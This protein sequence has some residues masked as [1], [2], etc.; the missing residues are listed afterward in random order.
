MVDHSTLVPR[1][2]TELLIYKLINF[3]ENK[4]ISILDI[5]TGSGCILLAILKELNFSK[6]I[7]IDV[8]KNAIQIARDA[9]NEYPDLNLMVCGD[10]ANT[11]IYDPNDNNSLKECQKMYEEQVA[12]AKE[13]N[14]DFIV[15]ETINWVEEMKIALKA[16]KQENIIAVANYAIP[17]GDKTR[18]GYSAEDSCKIME[19]G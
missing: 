17:R 2:E 3:F 16:I 19:G 10:V 7:G 4:K 5:G 14:V 9:A 18:D 1:P 13:A 8:S 11:N 15:A 6:G 12:W